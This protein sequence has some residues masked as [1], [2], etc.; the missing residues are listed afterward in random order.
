MSL[1]KALSRAHF[2][3]VEREKGF[4]GDEHFEDISVT[5]AD[6]SLG[7]ETI[8]V[9]LPTGASITFATAI[10]VISIMNDAATLQKID[11]DLEVDASSVFSQDDVVG[12][13]AVDGASASFLIAQNVSTI[14]TA[15]GN[16]TLEAKTTLSDAHSTHFT[17]QYMI[18]VA[19]RMS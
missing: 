2:D 1:E 12:L 5:T 13:A 7:S 4:S 15:V 17:T 9:V 16:H 10:A 19:Y 3:V 18:I 11:L 8:N 14:I 6:Q